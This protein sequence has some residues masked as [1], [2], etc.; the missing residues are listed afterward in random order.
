MP[1]VICSFLPEPVRLK[2]IGRV[3]EE[4]S[5]T[6]RKLTKPMRYQPFIRMRKADQVQWHPIMGEEKSRRI[7]WS[8]WISQLF[9]K[10]AKE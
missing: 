3:L 8:R 7:I 10:T 2:T 5:F 9:R 1:P 6:P 4:G